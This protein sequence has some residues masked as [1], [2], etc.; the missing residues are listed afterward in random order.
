M[1]IFRLKLE[2]KTKYIHIYI[3]RE[4]ERLAIDARP[5]SMCVHVCVCMHASVYVC[6]CVSRDVRSYKPRH[7]GEAKKDQTKALYKQ[8]AH[9]CPQGH[10]MQFAAATDCL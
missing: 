6:I 9:Q 3:E 4:R 1:V 5:A 10:A 7:V 2:K 8:Q